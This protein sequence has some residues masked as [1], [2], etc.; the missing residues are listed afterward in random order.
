MSAGD[1]L[2]VIG[3][4]P[5][6]L[7]C[8]IKA[9]EPELF[10]TGWLERLT[11]PF[12]RLYVRASSRL[13]VTEGY[14][15]HGVLIGSI[16]DAED[17]RPWSEKSR[18][19]IAS[20]R[21]DEACARDVIRT[22]FG[23][24]V[25]V[26]REAASAAVLRD[27]SG[28]LEAVGWRRPGVVVIASKPV[29]ALFPVDAKIDVDPLAIMA[30]RPGEYFHDL[31]VTGFA[32]VGAGALVDVGPEGWRATQLWR[33]ADLYR[34]R[35]DL[36]S[37]EA[38][39]RTVEMSV[40]ALAGDDGPWVA[41]V[42]G[43][44]DS[45]VV[46]AA[47]GRAGRKQV[48]G[49]V[50]HV[51][52]DAEGDESAYA[53]AVAKRLGFE[54]MRAPRL[55]FLLDED[56]LAQ[57]SSGFRPGTNDLDPGYNADI[58]RRICALGAA[59][60]ITGQ[61]GDA[62]F[63]QMATPLIGIDELQERGLGARSAVL[64]DV[65]RWNRR[66][67]WPGTWI[68]AWRNGRRAAGQAS[69]RGAAPHPWLEDLRGVPPAKRMQISALAYCQTFQQAAVR[70]RNGWCLNPLLSQPVVELGLGISSTD[71]TRGGRDRALVRSAFKDLLPELII[72]RRSKGDVS[73]FYGRTVSHNLPFLRGYLL[74]GRLAA[75]GLVDRSRLESEL[76]HSDLLWRGNHAEVLSL[77][78]LESWVRQW[79][80]RLS[81][82]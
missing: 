39:R 24:Y 68:K 34:R 44:L 59:G 22:A 67:A 14:D 79:Q 21:L 74:D 33:P 1:Y 76:A 77:A 41:E 30:K 40:R 16:Y 55:G 64:M 50:N 46:A 66:S 47:L 19:R 82:R 52:P 28:A 13:K 25:L 2:L 80:A 63:F 45:A 18:A 20:R 57:A 15:G 78:L 73:A 7:E 54:L 6:E 61:G 3:D 29:D 65:A 72:Q 81:K 62:V 10:R 38:I 69:R 70:T 58:D 26:R 37:H 23:G 32:P 71:L 43:G 36:P 60:A 9:A 27:P 31:A 42:S 12:L 17:G 49:W 51:F 8:A 11:S 35:G 53:D 4:N 5:H 56:V 75:Q 48:S